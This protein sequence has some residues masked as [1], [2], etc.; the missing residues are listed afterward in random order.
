MLQV[1]E[2]HQF[3]SE[4][5]QNPHWNRYFSLLSDQKCVGSNC[6]SCDIK[7]D[8]S[9]QYVLKKTTTLYPLKSA[10]CKFSSI[11]YAATCYI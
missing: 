4:L 6:S 5:F 8:N 1:K 10:T 9:N 7:F 11:I 2:V 3:T